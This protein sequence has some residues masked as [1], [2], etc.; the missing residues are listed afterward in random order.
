MAI[1]RSRAHAALRGSTTKNKRRAGARSYSITT[2][3]GS[4][5]RTPNQVSPRLQPRTSGSTCRF[6]ESLPRRTA[7]C[8][9]RCWG[10][11]ARWF[12]S[13]LGLIRRKPR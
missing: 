6:M 4:E 9:D 1:S 11:R 8:E 12:V 7:Q 10:C 5:T 3:L 13:P 2:A